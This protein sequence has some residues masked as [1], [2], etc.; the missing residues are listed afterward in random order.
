M[1]FT[2]Y[3]LKGANDIEFGMLSQ[4]VRKIVGEK[5]NSF[6]KFDEVHPSDHFVAAG[7]LGYY[8]DQGH[9]E[10]LEFVTPSKP[11]FGLT[12]MLDLSFDQAASLMKQVDPDVVVLPDM[13][14]SN[15]LSLSIWSSAGFEDG[16]E[17]V[18]AFLI[19]R[20]GYYVGYN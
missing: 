16:Y 7:L 5:P 18:E 3:P 11:M 10:A 15:R 9:L 13:V 8:D 20:A 4:D 1:E 14:T 12:S 17:P 2:I 6:T 19:G